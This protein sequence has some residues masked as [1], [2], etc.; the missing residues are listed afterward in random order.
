MDDDTGWRS[1]DVGWDS[2]RMVVTTTGTEGQTA[3]KRRRRFKG[4]SCQ[5]PFCSNPLELQYHKVSPGSAKMAP[6]QCSPWLVGPQQPAACAACGPRY[7]QR[8][9]GLTMPG[10]GLLT[11]C[12][13][14]RKSMGAISTAHHAA[15][16]ILS[17]CIAAPFMSTW[18]PLA[19]SGV[20]QYCYARSLP[21]LQKYHVSGHKRAGGWTRGLAPHSSAVQR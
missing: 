9:P 12:C 16:T 4:G 18:E 1:Q 7:D 6:G 8:R 3:R 14:G 15:C 5:V 20:P 2:S 17:Y 13:Q 19:L 11:G 10:P 21:S